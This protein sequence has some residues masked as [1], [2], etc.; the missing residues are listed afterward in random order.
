MLRLYNVERG[1]G[2]GLFVPHPPALRPTT[3]ERGSG[4]TRRA[5]FLCLGDFDVAL[6]FAIPHLP[7]LRVCDTL[8]GYGGG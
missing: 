7:S 6:N 5:K 4:W 1:R 3:R 2:G 8:T